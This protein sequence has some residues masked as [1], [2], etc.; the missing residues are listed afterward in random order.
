MF[1][2]CSGAAKNLMSQ[3]LLY[4]YSLKVH[5]AVAKYVLVFIILYYVLN[6]TFNQ[7]P[8]SFILSLII[9]PLSFCFPF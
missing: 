7:N 1:F 4:P 5:E 3:Y 8:L 6:G 2:L 9:C